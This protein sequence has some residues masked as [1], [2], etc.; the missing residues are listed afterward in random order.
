MGLQTA[1]E[2]AANWILNLDIERDK[3]VS[4]AGPRAEVGGNQLSLPGAGRRTL[5]P[6]GLADST[7]HSLKPW[8]V[9]RAL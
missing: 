4:A 9:P 2:V 6:F 7:W 1:I 5:K 8:H 3:T